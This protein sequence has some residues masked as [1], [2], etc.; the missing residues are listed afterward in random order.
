MLVVVLLLVSPLAAAGNR[1]AIPGQASGVPLFTEVRLEDERAL[2]GLLRFDRFQRDRVVAW[3]PRLVPLAEGG[4]ALAQFWLGRLYDFFEFG[5]GTPEEAGV[6]MTWYTRAADQHLVGAEY[7][8]FKVYEYSLLGVP[9]DDR[10]ARAFLDRAYADSTGVAKAEFALDLARLDL[11][12]ASDASPELTLGA[13]DPAR[14]LRYLEE[15]LRL[16][17]ENQ[18]VIDW[19]IDIYAERGD[20]ARAVELAERSRNSAMIEKAASLCLHELHDSGCSIRLLRRSRQ[21]PRDDATPPDALL[22]LYTLVC[23]KQLARSK[24]GAIDTPAAWRFFMKWQRNCVVN[25]GG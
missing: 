21:F 14:G 11:H 18:Q 22:D 1:R 25:P 23:R 7:F 9:R 5:Q 15:A 24:L 3:R 13:P 4:D 17:P 10:K 12:P 8:L 19:W 6:A 2:A 20:H 16:D